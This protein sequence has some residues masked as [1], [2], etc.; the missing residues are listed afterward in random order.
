MANTAGGRG[1]GKH[2][3][4]T[5][6]KGVSKSPAQFKKVNQFTKVEQSKFKKR[7]H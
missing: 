6:K 3:P 4:T 1:G 7:G 2:K 5:P